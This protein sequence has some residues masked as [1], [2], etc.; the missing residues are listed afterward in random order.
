[1][2]KYLLF[3]LIVGLTLTTATNTHGQM[4]QEHSDDHHHHE[5]VMISEGQP[6]PSVDLVVHEDS[7]RGWNLEIK[8]NNFE[9]TPEMV[10]QE[11][12]PNQGHAHL[13][14]NGEK[15]TR[16]Y[17]NWYYLP[18]LPSGTN[19]IKVSLNTNSHE[20][21]MYQGQLI[22]AVEVIEVK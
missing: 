18:T 19:E 15:I 16:I 8:L 20:M 17:S 22:E 3:S 5:T 6:V 7:L 11:N 12:Q 9:L 4:H 14:I 2:Q 21:L 13:Y 1:M 10:N